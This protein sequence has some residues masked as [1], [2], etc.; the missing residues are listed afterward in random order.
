[1]VYLWGGWSHLGACGM[2]VPQPWIEPTHTPCIVSMEPQPL[3][4]QGST[5]L[6][7]YYKSHKFV[8]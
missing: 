4:C 7:Y 1:M 8:E 6:K 5:N 2:L 3:Y